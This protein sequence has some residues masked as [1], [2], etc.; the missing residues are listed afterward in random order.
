MSEKAPT[1][2]EASAS[3]QQPAPQQ[4]QYVVQEKSLQGIGGFLVFWLI[5]FGLYS[6]SFLFAFFI[7]LAGIVESGLPSGVGGAVVIETMIFGLLICVSYILTV[8]FITMQKK[9]GRILSFVSIALTAL[10]VVVICLTSM[11]AQFCSKSYSYYGGYHETC[12]GIGAGGIIMLIAAIMGA[13]IYAGLVSL[14]FILSKRVKLTL[15]K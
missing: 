8:V 11:F 1:T 2:P 7:C 14:Y 5:V 13:L 9:L 3:L 6:V 4:V 10:F 12:S 15:V